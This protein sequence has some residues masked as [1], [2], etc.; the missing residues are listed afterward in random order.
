MAKQRVMNTFTHLNGE[1]MVKIIGA[2]NVVVP[3]GI[4]EEKNPKTT[5]RDA[6]SANMMKA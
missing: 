6:Q 3:V 5:Q 4:K 1:L 2:A